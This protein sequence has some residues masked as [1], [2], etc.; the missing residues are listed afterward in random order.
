MFKNP[1][2]EDCLELLLE[3]CRKLE[4]E[5][6]A[7]EALFPKTFV[8]PTGRFDQLFVEKLKTVNPSF[9]QLGQSARVKDWKTFRETLATHAD[10]HGR[11]ARFKWRIPRS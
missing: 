4:A 6:A 9:S 7:L 3:Y 5:N 8:D 10:D 1:T 2:A 11:L